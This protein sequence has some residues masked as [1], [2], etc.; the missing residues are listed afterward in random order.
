MIDVD[1]NSIDGSLSPVAQVHERS[2]GDNV[3]LTAL[4]DGQGE[5]INVFFGAKA[6]T[7]PAASRSRTRHATGT[8]PG[9]RSRRIDA[10][11]EPVDEPRG[12]ARGRRRQRHTGKTTSRPRSPWR[13]R[14]WR[15]T[16]PEPAAAQSRFIGLVQ[17]TPK[18]LDDS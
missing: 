6:T 8:S 9:Q 14:W 2:M 12:P 1:G 5:D 3:T 11:R 10:C 17:E 15:G 4:R 16:A 7:C 18:S 13:T